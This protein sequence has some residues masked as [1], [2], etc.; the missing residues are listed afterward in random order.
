MGYNS[1]PKLIYL[2]S[3]TP[4][5]RI[6]CLKI[7]SSSAHSFP[8]SL[9][10]TIHT[11]STTSSPS[12][13]TPPVHIPLFPDFNI[14]TC[15]RTPSSPLPL[16]HSHFLFTHPFF[17]LYHLH[18][19]THPL[20][21]LHLFTYPLHHLH[22]LFTHPLLPPSSFTPVYAPPLPSSPFTPPVHA[23]SSFPLH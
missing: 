10:I 5:I 18:L 6:F 2:P 11:Y 16:H 19:F 12:P 4:A 22:L 3:P 23:P 1:R 15:S 21:H 9:L 7:C 13:F 20:H 8:P 14:H 17:P